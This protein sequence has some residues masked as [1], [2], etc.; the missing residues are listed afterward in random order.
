MKKNVCYDLYSYVIQMCQGVIYVHNLLC[1][2]CH[3]EV[4]HIGF[5]PSSQ[6]K[7][8]HGYIILSFCFLASHKLRFA[9]KDQT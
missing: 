1:S 6:I 9:I 3:S 5:F 7:N 4:T 2:E 8:E